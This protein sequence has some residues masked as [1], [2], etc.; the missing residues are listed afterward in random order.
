MSLK[1][2]FFLRKFLLSPISYEKEPSK[3]KQIYAFFLFLVYTC[4]AIINFLYKLTFYKRRNLM[5]MVLRIIIDFDIYFSLVFPIVRIKK[6][7]RDWWLLLKNISQICSTTNIKIFWIWF[8]IFWIIMI[9]FKYSYVKT[10]GITFIKLFSFE[11]IQ[12]YSQYFEVFTAITIL[13]MLKQAYQ[14]EKNKIQECC[15]LDNLKILKHNLF[16]L[17]NC[18][19][20]FNKI[21]GWNILFNH[22]FITCRTLVYIDFSIKN[23]NSR[24]TTSFDEDIQFFTRNLTLVLFWVLNSFCRLFKKIKNV[25]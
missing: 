16:L 5:R 13:E 10:M 7:T 14:T 24:Y 15:N 1:Q 20:Y 8:I 6:M 12:I 25:F 23:E 18:V 2:I 21:F 22:I 11:L 9:F 3:K 4:G 19:H 17:K